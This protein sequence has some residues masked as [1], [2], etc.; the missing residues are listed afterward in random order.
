MEGPESVM[1]SSLAASKQIVDKPQE[2]KP[3]KKKVEDSDDEPME[4]SKKSKKRITKVE[5]DKEYLQVVE[6]CLDFMEQKCYTLI[7]FH[8]RC[9]KNSD[10]Q[11][12][13]SEFE[14]TLTSTI[15]YEFSSDKM[16]EK[17]FER[18]A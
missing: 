16:F 10:N 4:K 5:I 12:S 14:K 3:T 13:I 1:K 6:A 17:V 2:K 18:F 7:A 9:D 11:I 8:R 15:E